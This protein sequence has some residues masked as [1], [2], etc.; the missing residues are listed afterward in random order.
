MAIVQIKEVAYVARTRILLWISLVIMVLALALAGCRD[1][2]ALKSLAADAVPDAIREL[3]SAQPK[4]DL[5][6]RTCRAESEWTVAALTY[7]TVR[8]DGSAFD[9]FEVI[10]SIQGEDGQIEHVGT[11]FRDLPANQPFLGSK[12]QESRQT[13]DGLVYR[14]TAS[15][16]AFDRRAVKVIGVTSAGTEVHCTIDNGFW[17]L[18][19]D[20]TGMAETWT[21]VTAVDDRGKVLHSY[22]SDWRKAQ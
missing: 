15:G 8:S 10:L 3:V 2:F 11:D 13:E 20:N 22:D 12:G 16:I 19:A 5:V 1:S 4:R 7:K 17:G 21:S 6:W 18:L 14:I 9:S